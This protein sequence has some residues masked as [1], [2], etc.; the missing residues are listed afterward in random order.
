MS[1]DPLSWFAQ[2][3]GVFPDGIFIAKIGKVLGSLEQDG[4][5][6]DEP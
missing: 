2:E 4:N 1:A 5:P 3:L 6:V